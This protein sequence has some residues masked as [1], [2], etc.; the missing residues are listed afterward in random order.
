VFGRSRTVK[1]NSYGR[2]RSRWRL[3]RWLL[4]LVGGV[5]MGAAALAY[6]QQ[7]VLPP[8]LSATASAELRDAFERADAE[9]QRLTGELAQAQAELKA[10]LVDKARLGVDLSAHRATAER[11][12]DDLAAVV[13]ALPPDPRGGSVEVRAG[14]FTTEGA[15]FNYHVVLLRERSQGKPIPGVLQFV[16]AG[17]SARGTPTTLTL[18][19]IT[20]SMGSHEV[21]RGSLPLPEGFK[22][23]QTTVQVLDRVAGKPLGMRVILVK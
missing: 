20:L 2:Q 8:R 7:R 18:K 12:R 1:F 5:V 3:P 16:V 6:L 22:P 13:T 11:L 23:R 21:V 4:L 15:A 14:R 19:P 10:V 9:R 17:E